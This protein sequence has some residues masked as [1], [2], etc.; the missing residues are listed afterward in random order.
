MSGIE[1]LRERVTDAERCF[2]SN[3]SQRAEYSE[4]LMVM[5]N[6][7]EGRIHEQQDEIAQQAANIEKYEIEAA[8][9][10]TEI[11][12]QHTALAQ[13]AGE[14]EKLQTAGVGT[15]EENEE[16]RDMLHVLLQAIETSGRD[17]LA[18]AMQELERKASALVDPVAIAPVAES[19]AEESIERFDESPAEAAIAVGSVSTAPLDEADGAGIEAVA[20]VEAELEEIAEPVTEAPEETTLAATPEAA[21]EYLPEFTAE[22]A[23]ETTAETTAETAAEISDEL[24]GGSLDEIMERVSRLVEET[25]AAIA[26]PVPCAPEATSGLGAE[27]VAN[28]VAE[29]LADDAVEAPAQLATGTDS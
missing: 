25:E 24:P 1:E 18:E 2:G 28:S 16:L 13:Q 6:A 27:W 19:A 29:D 7:V 21:S 22:M 9:Q 5:M 8:A 4:R 26:M 10:R 3:G 15:V 23:A 12:G 20:M 14:I 11:D 17:G